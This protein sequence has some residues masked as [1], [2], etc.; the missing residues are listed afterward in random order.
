VNVNAPSRSRT[1]H[2][3]SGGAKQSGWGREGPRWAIQEMTCLKMVSI[4]P[5]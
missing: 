5:S 1:D 3:P 2:E 4:A